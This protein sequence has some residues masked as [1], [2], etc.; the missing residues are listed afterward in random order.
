MSYKIAMTLLKQTKNK[1][2]KKYVN[3]DLH[4]SRAGI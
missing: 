1:P 2:Y 4:Q 3:I